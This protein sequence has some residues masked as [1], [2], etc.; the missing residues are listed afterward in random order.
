MN[1]Q[2]VILPNGFL[3]DKDF[4]IRIHT[5]LTELSRED[6]I[7]FWGLVQMARQPEYML[8]EHIL[9][10]TYKRG[11]LG[12]AS[13]FHYSNQIAILYLVEGRDKHINVISLEKLKKLIS[14]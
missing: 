11:L 5:Q 6:G 14:P 9:K 12:C 13:S 2:S 1:N 4:L 8:P 3:I 10:D 7:R